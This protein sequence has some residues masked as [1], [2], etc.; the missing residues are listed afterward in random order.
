CPICGQNFSSKAL[1]MH[2][3]SPV[4]ATPIYY[5]PEN[6][7]AS[8]GLGEKDKH[9]EERAFKTLSSLMQH[10]EAGPCKRGKDSWEKAMKFL[11]STLEGFRISGVKLLDH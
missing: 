9:M 11:E 2:I 10:I 5:C 4:H 1:Q 7:L 3:A 8:I 6:L